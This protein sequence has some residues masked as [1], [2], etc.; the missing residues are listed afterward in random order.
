MFSIFE[1]LD[2]G[3]RTHIVCR[4]TKIWKS[5]PLQI[6]ILTHWPDFPKPTGHHGKVWNIQLF[7][8]IKLLK[9]PIGKQLRYDV[10]PPI[11]SQLMIPPIMFS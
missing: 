11:V 2:P 3:V 9:N 1:K 7:F 6:F 10:V 5:F 8:C 4:P